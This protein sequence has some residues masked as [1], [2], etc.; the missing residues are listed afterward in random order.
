MRQARGAGRRRCGDRPGAAARKPGKT[1]LGA[2]AR[3]LGERGF[4]EVTV[5]TGAKLNGSL[6]PR[7][8]IDEIILVH[9]A[10]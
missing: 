5:E 3:L 6:S 1:D 9:G 7:A 2:V 10:A 4:N 8:S